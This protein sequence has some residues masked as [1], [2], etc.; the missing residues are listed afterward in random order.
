MAQGK[1]ILSQVIIDDISPYFTTGTMKFT[2]P[3]EVASGDDI[4]L[5]NNDYMSPQQ[6]MN[7]KLTLGLA[8][9]DGNITLVKQ[10]KRKTRYGSITVIARNQE[11]E[12]VQFKFTNITRKTVLSNEVGAED[13]VS[14]EI[15]FGYG[16]DVLIS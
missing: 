13:G 15:E 16:N 8:G 4:R 7:G 10:L 5:T 3:Q 1:Y 2:D 9:V 12:E 11:Q 14:T 6:I